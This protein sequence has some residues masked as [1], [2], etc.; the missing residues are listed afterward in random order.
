MAKNQRTQF[1]AFLDGLCSI[2]QLDKD[3]KPVQVL[4]NI[5]FQNRVVGY[6]RNYA[7]EQ[8]QYHIER[9][10]RIPRADNITR[11]A[12]V[13]IGEE[14]YSVIQAQPKLDTIPN[15][16]DLTLGQPEILLDFDPTQAGSGGR[17]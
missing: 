8:A 9:I 6:K 1:E 16:T 2:W 10:I 13:V 7:A 11:G 14:Q 15:C 5:R 12:F 4:A 3:M 17:M